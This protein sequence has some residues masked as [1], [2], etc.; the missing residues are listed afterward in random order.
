L[1]YD[2]PDYNEKV[3][4]PEKE[5]TTPTS[6]ASGYGSSSPN[7]Y[8]NQPY[9]MNFAKPATMYLQRPYDPRYDYLRPD[10]KT[11]GSREAY[12]RDNL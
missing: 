11:Q 9:A 5:T 4:K 6:Y 1:V 8:V 2:P 7:L 3:E 12:S 10:V